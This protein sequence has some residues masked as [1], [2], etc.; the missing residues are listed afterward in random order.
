MKTCSVTVNRG[1]DVWDS[2]SE[3]CGK[4]VKGTNS[5]GDEVCGVHLR[6]DRMRQESDARHNAWRD[7]VE[8]VNTKLGIHLSCY[9]GPDR[10]L[11]VG[12]KDMEKLAARWPS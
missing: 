8:A 12:L 6:S 10:P 7:R 3:P 11:T 1:F 2:R 4:P 5:K 9:D